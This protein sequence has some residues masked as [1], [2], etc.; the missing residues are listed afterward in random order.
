[1]LSVLLH[2]LSKYLWL[3][4]LLLALICSSIGS[5]L[6]FVMVFGELARLDAA[7]SSFAVAFILS[8]SPGFIGTIVGKYLLQRME[9]KYCLMIGELLGAVGL[10][11]PWFGIENNAASV[12]QCAGIASSLAAGLT[13][14][15]INHYTKSKLEEEDIGAG[16]LIDTFVFS[17]HVLFG[18]GI[19]AIIYEKI[20]SETFLLL[21]L[22][23][24]F[25]AI[26]VISL[27]PII[28]KQPSQQNIIEDLPRNLSTRQISSLY[29]L[30]A[31]AMVGSPAMSLLPTLVGNENKGDTIL[32]LLFSR[33][34]GQLMGP[35]LVNEERY[36]SQSSSF[37]IVCMIV[38]IVCYLLVPISPN[39]IV[40]LAFVFIAHIFSNI[41]YSMGWYN[42]LTNFRNEHVAAASASSYK[43]QIVIGA[44]A[45]I[46]SG[47][48][49]DR[50]GSG[51]ALLVCSITGLVLSSLLIITIRTKL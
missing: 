12:L 39:L 14:P 16:A 51:M 5:G 36:K 20:S 10:G 19:G 1:M 30:P 45:S 3:R 9:T 37:I 23:S 21:N 26:V 32:Y 47:V 18:I 8:T 34:L 43:R 49:A 46:L 24:Y 7:P 11:I 42:I 40:S 17:C 28:N 50:I 29:L 6:T 41:I 22:A 35:F 44:V 15:A 4:T 31:L 33:G 48:L 2:S 27:L 38:F 13:I 25:F